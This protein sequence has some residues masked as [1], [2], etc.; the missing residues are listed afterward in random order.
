VD[1]AVARHNVLGPVAR[2]DAAVGFFPEHAVVEP[3]LAEL[4]LGLE[5][6]TLQRLL[7]GVQL[8]KLLRA[9]DHVVLEHLGRHW[10]VALLLVLLKCRVD[11]REDSVAA[12][13]EVDAVRLKGVHEAAEA[14]VLLDVILPAAVGRPF[15]SPEDLWAHERS[16]RRDHIGAH[17]GA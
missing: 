5:G 8:V 7:V 13:G 15:T 12:R 11:R 4:A 3:H 9:K 1:D 17:E 10:P 16:Q 6:G 14:V 2:S